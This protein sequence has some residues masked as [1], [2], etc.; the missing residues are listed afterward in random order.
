MRNCVLGIMGSAVLFASI[1]VHSATAASI[2]PEMHRPQLCENASGQKIIEDACNLAQRL[3]ESVFLS[4]PNGRDNLILRMFVSRPFMQAS[5]I[6]VE[7]RSATDAS[8]T[9]R[10][11]GFVSVDKTI[12]LSAAEI[13]T[14]KQYLARSRFH[15]TGPERDCAPDLFLLAEVVDNHAY[16]ETAICNRADAD[17]FPVGPLID[18]IMRDRMNFRG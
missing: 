18:E 16:R 17:E 4:V 12:T 7:I 8:L 6:R 3:G 5:I 15:D 14:I 1:F 13:D 11:G 9:V 10:S 2:V